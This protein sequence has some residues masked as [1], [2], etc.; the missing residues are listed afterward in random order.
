M[1]WQKYLDWSYAVTQLRDADPSDEVVY[2]FNWTAPRDCSCIDTSRHFYAWTPS[3][4]AA[5]GKIGPNRATSDEE[6]VVWGCLRIPITATTFL[7]L[8][9]VR[10]CKSYSDNILS[11]A[12]VIAASN[13]I[14]ASNGLHDPSGNIFPLGAVT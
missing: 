13:W 4:A 8:N 6:R 9:G 14:P 3:E 5:M 1:R 7:V 11:V 12:H 2:Y 10:Y